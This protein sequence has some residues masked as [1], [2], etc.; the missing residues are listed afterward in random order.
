MHGAARGAYTL[1]WIIIT[2]IVLGCGLTIPVV[3]AE[4][5]PRTHAELL[6]L[7][8]RAK[9]AF[10]RR[11]EP[12]PIRIMLDDII[13]R[14]RTAIFRDYARESYEAAIDA[15]LVEGQALRVKTALRELVNAGDADVAEAISKEILE[16]K[17]SQGDHA[18]RDT[19]AAARHSVALVELPAAL[20][21]VIMPS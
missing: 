5:E 3:G 8:E 17:A 14:D 18:K 1:F 19:A 12:P 13:T 9:A 11:M 20:A 6:R 7:A 4:G 16:R 10:R 21:P 2:F 15:L